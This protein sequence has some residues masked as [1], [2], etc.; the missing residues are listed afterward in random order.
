MA[1]V[2]VCVIGTGFAGLCMAIQL[3]RQGI[4]DFVILDK[5]EK[6][7]GTWR[8]NSYPGAGCDVPS[9]LYSYSFELK[10]DWSRRFAKQSEIVDYIEHCA[11]KY[12][13]YRHIRFGTEVAEARFDE[14]RG[15]WSVTTKAGAVIEAEFVVSGLGQLSRPQ[16]PRIP[17]MDRFKGKAFHSAHWDHG[18]DLSGKRVVVIGSGASA[19]Q[20]VPEVQKAAKHLTLFQ[21][22]PAWMISKDDRVFSPLWQALCRYLPGFQ[23]AYRNYT[24]LLLESRFVS[25]RRAKGFFAWL[26]TKQCQSFL[27]KSV[28]DPALK[29]KLQPDFPVGCKRILISND[30][31]PALSQ[32]N[33]EVVTEGVRE[34]TETGV[35][36]TDGRTVEADCLIYGTGFETQSFIAPMK[37]WGRQGAELNERWRNGAEA[38]KGV[39]VA[40]FPNFF[41]LYGPNTN[42]GHNSIIFMIER[43]VGYILKCMKEVARRRAATL[44]VTP[45][46]M[47]DYNTRLQQDFE[48]TVWTANCSSWY[49]NAAGRITNNWPGFTVGYWWMMREPDF[50]DFRFDPKPR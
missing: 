44:D 28:T 32:P 42:L 24:Y 33:V 37:V 36:T 15:L 14:A 50:N 3:K 12:D 10:P 31:Y 40:G 21:R 30:W 7:G 20:F 35:V 5:A 43:Q 48:G 49:R 1:P 18:Y 39:A 16:F 47:S 45:D 23:R 8:E 11:R 38:H 29:A 6:V 13:L 26:A 2:K 27:D 22:S 4:E 17:G 34:I 46:A 9:H 41:V 25:F 19:V